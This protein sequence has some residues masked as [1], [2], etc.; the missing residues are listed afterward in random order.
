M[1]DQSQVQ[2]RRYEPRQTYTQTFGE[3]LAG[4]ARAQPAGLL[5]LVAG[6]SLLLSGMRPTSREATRRARTAVRRIAQGDFS[7]VTETASDV[8]SG[9]RNQVS[10]IGD[11]ASELARST[12]DS[13]SGLADNAQE[14]LRERTQQLV[15]TTRSS[16]QSGMSF[17]L[18]DQ[19]LLLAAIGLAAGATLGALLPGTPQENQLM[20]DV[21]DHVAELA[22]ETARQ[23]LG[24]LG[25][26]ATEAAERLK[27]AV[28]E[29]ASQATENLD[30]VAKDVVEPF[31]N[32][33]SGG[34][35]VSGGKSGQGS[36]AP[37]A[38]QSQGGAGS[39]GK[40]S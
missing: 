26:A 4:A 16:A 31:A 24:D 20:G 17:V 34:A 39:V 25:D 23:K 35:S 13:I 21:R 40:I 29:R 30:E 1:T 8:A 14:A 6:T 28:K 7:P 15:E 3:R 11:K 9:V 22:T 12:T 27:N 19:P 36:S 38:S 5:L 32:V 10:G 18:E 37:G 2:E 33:A